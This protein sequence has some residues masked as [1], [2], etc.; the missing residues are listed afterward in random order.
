[1]NLLG[2]KPYVPLEEVCKG[3]SWVNDGSSPRFSLGVQIPDL[4]SHCDS[5]GGKLD[6]SLGRTRLS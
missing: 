2:Q 1:M 6:V 3:H 4:V 5:G